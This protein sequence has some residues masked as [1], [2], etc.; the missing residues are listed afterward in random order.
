MTIFI[1]LG[2]TLLCYFLN[3]RVCP[4]FYFFHIPC[5]GCGLTRSLI[6]LIKCQP[7]TS[8]NY[9]PLGITIPFLF[10][11][12]IYCKSFKK[13]EKINII[14]KK[15]STFFILIAIILLI[16][17]ETINLKN[18]LLYTLVNNV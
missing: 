11:L 4:F 5:P 16:I 2:L 17:I 10:L 6:A 1:L 18:P 15:Y 9:N 7:L 13:T 14:L 3:I 12:Y 8:L